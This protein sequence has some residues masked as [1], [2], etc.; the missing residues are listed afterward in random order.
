MLDRRHVSTHDGARRAEIV[1]SPDL[2]FFSGVQPDSTDGDAK[3][4]VRSALARLDA[5]LEEMGEDQRSIFVIHVWLK[6]MR[7][8]GAMNAVWNTWA[9]AEDPPARTCVSG[10]LARPDLIVEL[11]AT[12]VR[13]G[14]TS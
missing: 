13:S 7:Y 1:A 14:A 6:D 3:E 4:Q 8:F 2:I 5:L 10:E 11:V 9:D 12:A